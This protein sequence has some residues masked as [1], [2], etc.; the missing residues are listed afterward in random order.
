MR[1]L[2]CLTPIVSPKSMVS[3]YAGIFAFGNGFASMMVPALISRARKLSKDV[4]SF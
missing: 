2:E 3:A 1:A 4:V